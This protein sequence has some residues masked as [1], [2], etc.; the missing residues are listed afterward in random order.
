[1]GEYTNII[2]VAVAALVCIGGAWLFIAGERSDREMMSFA[3]DLAQ[4]FVTL[5]EDEWVQRFRSHGITVEYVDTDDVGKKHFKLQ[6]GGL[7]VDFQVSF[8]DKP[9]DTET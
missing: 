3:N 5:G 1:M 6:R 2:L 8:K 9:T 7:K 4:S